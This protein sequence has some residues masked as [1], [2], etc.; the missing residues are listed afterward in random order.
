VKKNSELLM[1]ML[2]ALIIIGWITTG[3][4]SSS[5]RAPSGPAVTAPA[6]AH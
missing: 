4:G 3:H 2:I 1:G 5:G 6:K